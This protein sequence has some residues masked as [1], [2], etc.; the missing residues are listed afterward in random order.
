MKKRPPNG[1]TSNGGRKGRTD[2]DGEGRSPFARDALLPRHPTERQRFVLRGRERKKAPPDRLTHGRGAR[3]RTD[4]KGRDAP[5]RPMP[6]RSAARASSAMNHLRSPLIW[7]PR[8][9]FRPYVAS[10]ST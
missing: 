4:A 8:G 9:S 2:A 10:H 6:S 5:V 7:T 3:G 1:V